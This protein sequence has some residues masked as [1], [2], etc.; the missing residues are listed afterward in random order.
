M[1]NF[2][3]AKNGMIQLFDVRDV[4]VKESA[5][6]VVLASAIMSAG[7]PAPQIYNSSSMDHAE[8]YGF[9]GPYDAWNIWDRVCDLL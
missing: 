9:E 6:P 5:D 3:N 4:M 2:I 7:G 1:I 8:E